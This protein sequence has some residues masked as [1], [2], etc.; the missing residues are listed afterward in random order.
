MSAPHPAR[1]DLY[2]TN[3]GF[4]FSPFLSQAM[5]IQSACIES[6]LFTFI[7]GGENATFLIPN[8]QSLS[9][10]PRISI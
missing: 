2:L 10:L 1:G 9:E 4:F 3:T 8:A 6:E 7:F 5:L